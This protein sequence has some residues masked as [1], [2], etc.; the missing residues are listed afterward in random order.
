MDNKICNDNK[1]IYDISSVLTV[2]LSNKK[3][4]LTLSMPI[5]EMLGKLG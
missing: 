1:T 4:S 3:K 5:Y 2:K